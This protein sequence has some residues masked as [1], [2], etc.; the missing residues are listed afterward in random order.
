MASFAAG[1]ARDTKVIGLVSFGHLLSHF[2]FLVLPPILPLMKAEFGVSYAALGL[3]MSGYGLAAGIAQTPVG[4]LIDRIGGRPSLAVGMAMQGTTI[5]LMGF[6][7]EFW[8][9]LLLYSL[10]GLANTV[11]HPAN[12]AILSASIPR[13]RLGRAFS[14]HLFSGNFGWALT[15]GIM[16]GLT[17]MW[18]W[19][20]AFIIV[21][22]VAVVHAV[23]VWNQSH[24]LDDDIKARRA[25]IDERA[26][27]TEKSGVTGQDGDTVLSGVRL[28]FSLP[29]MMGFLFFACMTLGFTGLR[30][31][32]VA[33]MDLLYAMPL[34][35]ANTAL[36]GFLLGSAVGILAGGVLA[37][38]W[39]PRMGT[40]F[41]TLAAG[42][43][44]VI[45]MGTAI[46]PL[47]VLIAVFSASGFLQGVLLP[48]RDLL[49][50]SVTPEG[51]M[52]KVMGFLSSAIMLASAAVPP[53]FGW[54]LDASDPNWVFWLSAVF[55]LGALTSF[56]TAKGASRAA[57]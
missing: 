1:T 41:V 47:I 55:I 33:A 24:L 11:Y 34:Q 21:G 25:R 20:A 36:T 28:L 29:I 16:V 15:P 50:K 38:R 52:G 37:D 23:I 48:T 56:A 6:A 45:L 53:L 30:G 40:A 42:A 35:T 10:S 9:L 46:L 4:F 39:G 51:S 44:L 32:F 17:M 57:P 49:I 31:F 8:H 18:G 7:T 43:G 22:L 3:V 14:I 12:Y 27:E 5:A 19:R 54:I 2:N 26:R 13:E